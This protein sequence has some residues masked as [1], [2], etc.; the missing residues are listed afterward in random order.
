LISTWYDTFRRSRCARPLAGLLIAMLLLVVPFAISGCPGKTDVAGVE[1]ELPPLPS[2]V[3]EAEAPEAEQAVDSAG[4]AE[5]SAAEA[6]V[7]DFTTASFQDS[8]LGASTPVLVDF[9]APWCGPCEKMH[10]IMDGL[11]SEFAGKAIMGRVDIDDE[12][13][14]ASEYSIRAIP[15]VLLFSNGTVIDRWEGLAPDIE[16]QLNNAITKTLSQ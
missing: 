7:V 3:E 8:V 4:E 15:T 9:W 10:P 1:A 13:Q 16:Q 5:E 2:P 6:A 14:L 12:P 11:A